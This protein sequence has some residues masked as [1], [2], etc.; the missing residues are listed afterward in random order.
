MNY[1]I[2]GGTLLASTLLLGA[3]GGNTDTTKKDEA[4]TEQKEVKKDSGAL[5]LGETKKIDKTTF[6]VKEVKVTD[7]RNEFNDVKAEKVITVFSTVKSEN[8]EDYV[9]GQEAAV[10]VNGKKADEYALGSDKSETLSKGR[11][12]DVSQSF[13]VP[14]DAKEIEI[15]IKPLFS[16][17][18]EKALYKA[19]IK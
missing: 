10:Y 3:C 17:G 1:K 14:K 4:K 7:E 6:T 11:T 5:K 16:V 9:A 8:D 13:A 19:T 12:A 18:N 2:L 15:E